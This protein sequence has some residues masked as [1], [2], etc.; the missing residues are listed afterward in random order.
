MEKEDN[1]IWDSGILD[2]R[3]FWSVVATRHLIVM[4]SEAVFVLLWANP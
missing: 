1:R 2:I 3:I 4:K